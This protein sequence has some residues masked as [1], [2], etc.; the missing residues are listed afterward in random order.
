MLL[1]PAER[2]ENTKEQG[3]PCVDRKQ[4]A[5]ILQDQNQEIGGAAVGKP[6]DGQSRQPVEEGGRTLAHHLHARTSVGAA[7][8]L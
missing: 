4:A 3:K 5:A 1:L 8:Q 6:E 7:G 2:Y